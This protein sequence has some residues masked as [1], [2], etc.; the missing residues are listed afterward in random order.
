MKLLT[1]L[2]ELFKG[3]TTFPAFDLLFPDQCTLSVFTL[4]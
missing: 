2:D 4:F 1:S 3:V